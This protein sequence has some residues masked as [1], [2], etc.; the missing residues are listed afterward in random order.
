MRFATNDPTP[1]PPEVP[2]GENP[3][4][5]A[6]ID[7]YLA[8]DASGPVKLEILDAAGKV[9]RSYSSDNPVVRG[10]D[11]ATDPAKYN[12]LCQQTPTLPDCGLPLYW[13][14]PA[15]HARRRQ[16]GMHRFNWDLRYDPIGEGG[17]RGGGGGSSGAVPHRTYA[18][19]NAP[20]APPGHY[21]VRLT[22]DGKS[23]HAADRRCSLDPRVKTPAAGLAQLATLTRAAVRRRGGDAR[24]VRPGARA[25]R[26]LDERD[27]RRCR[28][29]QGAVDSIA[30]PAAAGGRGGR[31]G[32][33]GR[34][35]GGRGGAAGGTPTLES[36]STALMAAAMAMQSADVAPTASELEAASRA[37]G[38][39]TQVLA[40]LEFSKDDRPR[41]PQ[42]QE[43]S[44]RPPDG[45][46]PDRLANAHL[47]RTTSEDGGDRRHDR[48]PRLQLEVDELSGGIH[49]EEVVLAVQAEAQIDRAVDEPQVWP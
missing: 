30:P 8:T 42:R 9:V 19:V 22:V 15:L 4:P 24:G 39:S 27:R 35:R 32:R 12:T 38:R 3:P 14:A 1:W 29:V 20:W 7:Y 43:E 45:V 48:Q 46:D 31:G 6:L 13:P 10:T 36:A 37:R 23:V 40:S 2:A 47:P 17:G 41:R 28:G 11:P 25:G 26:Q 34:R 5:G 49:V 18:A 21:T 44:G 33:R 16:A